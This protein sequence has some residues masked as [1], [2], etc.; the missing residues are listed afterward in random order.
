MSGWE[1]FF[2]AEV[3]ASAALAGLVFVGPNGPQL[4]LS[5]FRRHVAASAREGGPARDPLEGPA[6]DQQH[7][8]PAADFGRKA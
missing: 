2:I 3:G 6:A 1:N 5:N 4:R 7:P 8:D